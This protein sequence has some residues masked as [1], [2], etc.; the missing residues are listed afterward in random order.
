[1]KDLSLNESD[2]DKKVTD[3]IV[4]ELKVKDAMPL[5]L[6]SLLDEVKAYPRGFSKVGTAFMKEIRGE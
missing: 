5:W 3:K 2:K 1:M 6:T 4:M